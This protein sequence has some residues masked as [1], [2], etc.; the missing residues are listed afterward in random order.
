MNA[1][2]NWFCGSSF[3]RRVTERHILPWLL[4]G[5]PLGEDVLELGAGP[6]ATTEVLSQRANH[7]TSLEYDRKFAARLG[8]RYQNTNVCILQGDA[9]SLPFPD[10][11][12]SSAVAILVLHHLKS[13]EQQKRA[14]AEIRRVLRP[15]G[16]LFA[17]E[18]NDSWINRV[19]HIKSTFV[20]IDPD[21]VTETL[22]SLEFSNV[23][24]EKQRGA[25]R[26]CACL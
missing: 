23:L 26:I 16:V 15:G 19:G 6:G 5:Y 9:A 18:I 20:P 24:V 3:W 14:F 8:V 4:S 17:L 11:V 10:S 12:F 21:S 22:K 7:V 25:Y 13:Q 2:E 1:F